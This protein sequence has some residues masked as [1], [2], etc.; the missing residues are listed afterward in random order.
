MKKEVKV[1]CGEFSAELPGVVLMSH[2]S[3]AA[4]LQ[5]TAQMLLGNQKNLTALCLEESDAPDDYRGVM[6]QCIENF[7]GGCIVLLDLFGGT[8]CNQLMVHM[9]TNQKDVFAVTGMNLPMAVAV[10]SARDTEPVARL[11][12]IAMEGGR[13]G[14]EDVLQKVRG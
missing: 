2:G 10:L 11:T 8:P 5:E 6:A 14:M 13:Q 3:L 12:E 7:P 9:L 4:G 1:L